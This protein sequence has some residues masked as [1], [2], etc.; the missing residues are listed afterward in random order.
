MEV[1]SVAEE[2]LAF[3]EGVHPVDRVEDHL[4]IQEAARVDIALVVDR[5]E[6]RV[7]AVDR[8]EDT[9]LEEDIRLVEIDLLIRYI[10]YGI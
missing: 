4:G 7:P 3:E 8:A 10:K 2:V 6:D 1:A 9:A 5:A